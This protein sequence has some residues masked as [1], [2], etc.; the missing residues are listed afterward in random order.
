MNHTSETLTKETLRLHMNRVFSSKTDQHVGLELEVIPFFWPKQPQPH[1]KPE[2]VYLHSDQP[3]GLI[4]RLMS[5]H[6]RGKC[7]VTQFKNNTDDPRLPRFLFGNGAHLTFE[8]GG[9]LEYSSLPHE[10][11]E[12][13]VGELMVAL[14]SLAEELKKED[15]RFFYGG[16][17]PWRTPEEIPLQLKKDRYLAMDQHFQRISPAGRKMMR[18]SSSMQV[19]LDFGS[20]EQAVRRWIAANAL[21]PVAVALFGNSPYYNGTA[22]GLKSMRATIWQELDP[23]RTGFLPGF[24]PKTLMEAQDPLTL[25]KEHYLEFALNARIMLPPPPHPG[26]DYRFRDWVEGRVPQRPPTM[27]DWERHLTTLFPEVRARGFMEIRYL[28][29]QPKAYWTVP[30]FFLRRLLYHDACVAQILKDAKSATSSWEERMRLAAIQG[31]NQPELRELAQSY[32]SLALDQEA[33]FDG[34][35]APIVEHFFKTLTLQ[36]M[37]PADHLLRRF[38]PLAPDCHQWQAYSDEMEEP[39]EPFT[40]SLLSRFLCQD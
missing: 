14:R 29:A 6:N 20:G 11:Y 23:S 17:N 32:M 30:G 39:I 8:P 22:N 34:H 37:N 15:I 24:D 28:D 7:H 25:I 31:L 10:D 18:L 33:S 36:G 19:N 2:P 12:Q 40:Q 35:V 9:Q 38:G 16:I 4:P 26:T 5:I 3:E 13:T 1:R 21:A 27:D